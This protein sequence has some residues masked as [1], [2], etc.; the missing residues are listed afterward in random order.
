MKTQIQIAVVAGLILGAGCDK[1]VV[2]DRP[3]AQVVRVAESLAPRHEPPRHTKTE[4]IP[5]QE[6]T[7][8]FDEGVPGHKFEHHGITFR[9]VPA[10]ADRTGVTV[11]AYHADF[12]GKRTAAP[13]IARKYLTRLVETAMKQERQPT[14]APAPGPAAPVEGA[15]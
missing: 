6:W 10:D 13:R 9:I 14:P 12:M 7:V 4:G 5:G 1:T 8:Q 2:I 3:P 11:T 15:R